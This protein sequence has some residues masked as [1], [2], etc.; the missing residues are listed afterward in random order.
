MKHFNKLEEYVMIVTIPLML[1]VVILATAVRYFQLG[2]LPWGEELAR[3]LMICSVYA[4]IS[5]GFRSN[6]HL[7]LNFLVD[8]LPKNLQK[9]INFIRMLLITLFGLI[10]AYSSSQIVLR[11]MRT[12]QRSAGLGIPMWWVYSIMVVGSV[13]LLIRAAQAYF[14]GQPGKEEAL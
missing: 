14:T 1:F 8:Q 6:S 9:F 13:L 12:Y 5:L 3:Y 11:Q 10:I 7:G 4:G 2:S